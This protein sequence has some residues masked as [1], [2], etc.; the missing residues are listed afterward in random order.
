MSSAEFTE[1]QA[2]YLLDP[3]D[4]DKLMMA[5]IAHAVYTAS[6]RYKPL[7]I[8][9]FMPKRRVRRKP[10]VGKMQSYFKALAMALRGKNKAE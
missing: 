7:K 1:W 10:D 4:E 6:G 8:E 5:Q 2:E 9:E 3:W